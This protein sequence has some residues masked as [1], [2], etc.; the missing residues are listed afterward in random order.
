MPVASGQRFPKA[1]KVELQ[2]FRTISARLLHVDG[3]V[4]EAGNIYRSLPLL[5]LAYFR[6]GR[7]LFLTVYFL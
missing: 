1:L 6:E 2:G 4:D 7:L 5:F 3:L